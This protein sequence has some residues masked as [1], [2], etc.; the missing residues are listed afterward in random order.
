M[1]LMIVMS[2]LGDA[3]AQRQRARSKDKKLSEEICMFFL[4]RCE[5]KMCGVGGNNTMQSG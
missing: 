1:L 5:V 4:D 2:G 3:K